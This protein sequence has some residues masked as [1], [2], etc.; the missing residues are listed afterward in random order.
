MQTRMKYPNETQ[1]DLVWLQ[2]WYRSVCNGDREH[3]HGIQIQTIDNPGWKF[4]VSLEET[5]WENAVWES[6][7]VEN[8]PND[9]YILGI[10][11]QKF[12]ATGDPSKLDFFLRTFR[13][14]I[15]KG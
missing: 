11:D 9:W 5:E 2:E 14:F 6:Q 8:S 12:L 10:K 3:S 7:M 15:E 13:E 1:N 4:V